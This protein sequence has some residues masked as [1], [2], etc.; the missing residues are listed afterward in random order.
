M[1][2]Y[3]KV[4][5]FTRFT[6]AVLREVLVN[7]LDSPSRGSE[8]GGNRPRNDAVPW[9]NGTRLSDATEAV[10]PARR[11]GPRRGGTAAGR[12]AR[13]TVNARPWKHDRITK[14]KSGEG[15]ANSCVSV[16]RFHGNMTESRRLSCYFRGSDR[17]KKTP[18][19]HG[20][21]NLDAESRKAFGGLC[22]DPP[23][24]QSTTSGSRF[25]RR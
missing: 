8:S 5:D 4:V 22:T 20:V 11:R 6:L 19:P 23:L 13:S 21:I 15:Q 3:N 25:H 9:G 16:E 1:T 18:Q 2:L 14:I 24:Q 10:K 17:H 7:Q 12:G